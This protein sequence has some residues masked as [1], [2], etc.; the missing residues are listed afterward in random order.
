MKFTEML[1]NEGCYNGMQILKPE[2]VRAMYT[3]MAYEH[4]I[5]IPGLEWG[6]GSQSP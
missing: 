1:C 4:P 6:T 5:E 2:T 3:E